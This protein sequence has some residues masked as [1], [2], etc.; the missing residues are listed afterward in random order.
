MEQKETG[1]LSIVI[2]CYNEEN[3][4]ETIVDK[5]IAS[6]VPKKEIIIVD[7]CSKDNTRK[8]LEE[9]IRPKVARIKIGRAHV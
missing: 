1:V 3:T 7:D 9:K 6:P 2:P 4:I 5:V 8:I